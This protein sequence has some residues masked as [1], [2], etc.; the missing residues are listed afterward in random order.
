MQVRGA[1]KK[2]AQAIVVPDSRRLETAADR[3]FRAQHASAEPQTAQTRTLVRRFGPSDY[4]AGAGHR[5]VRHRERRGPHCE[6][7]LHEFRNPLTSYLTRVW[8]EAEMAAWILLV[9]WPGRFWGRD[10]AGRRD[11]SEC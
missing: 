3:Q 6:G 1:A 8:P 4:S 5:A 9:R 2:R 11:V 7:H 10:C